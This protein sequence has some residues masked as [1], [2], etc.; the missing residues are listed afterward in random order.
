MADQPDA[1]D[2]LERLEADVELLGLT[3]LADGSVPT[4][5]EQ[6]LA[7]LALLYGVPFEHLVPDGSMLPV[8]SIR[9][10]HVDA[11]W[12][13]AMVDGAFSVGVHS[14]RD[15]RF[16][17]LLQPAVSEATAVASGTLR[18]RL[19][20][21]SV[22]EHRAAATRDDRT[23]GGFLLRS[24]IVA[25]WPGLE[26]AGYR[27]TS[28]TSDPVEIVRL[29]RLTPDLLFCLF[30]EIPSL[31]VLSEPPEGLHFGVGRQTEVPRR[32]GG[33]L[34]LAELARRVNATGTGDLAAALV[35]PPG[36]QHFVVP[37][38]TTEEDPR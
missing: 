19:R 26:V 14:Q 3:E 12:I 38:D 29:D 15:I 7:R 17:R 13:A 9:F 28:T 25:G 8:E 32:S 27:G 4:E 10:F 6:W 16:H 11:N 35:D 37:S 36:A 1:G 23:R 30:A 33:R 34:N 31:V 24:Q 22:P 20:G 21:E 5:V 2:P 18:R